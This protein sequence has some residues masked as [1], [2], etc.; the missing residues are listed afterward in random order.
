MPR[1]AALGG[2]AMVSL[3]AAA[4]DAPRRI[5]SV[6]MCADQL[7]LALADPGQIAALSW[8]AARPALSFYA[9]RAVDFPTTRGEAEDVIVRQPDLVLAGPFAGGV[10][11]AAMLRAGLRVVELDVPEDLE[12]AARQ[13]EDFGGLI[14]QGA[15]G[16]VEAS[17]LR[18]AARESGT[19][20]GH[21]RLR[22]LY[23]QRRGIATGRGTMMD[24][25]MR[26]AGLE[27]AVGEAGYARIGI[28]DLA[29]IDADLLILDGQG[30]RAD[31]DAADQGAAILAHPVASIRFPPERRV[32]VPQSELICAGPALAR[33]LERLRKV[34]RDAAD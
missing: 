4:T 8:N 1:L 13:L 22:A 32:I 15:R 18:A 11:K 10:A 31:G 24:A 17:K 30:L 34:A 27:N 19:G 2:I 20:E 25:L 12:A 9:D 28:E 6:N 5:V 23:L 16:R 33:A 14:G 3:P 29:T 7:L 26:A 21:R